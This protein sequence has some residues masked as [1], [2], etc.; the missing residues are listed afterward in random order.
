MVSSEDTQSMQMNLYNMPTPLLQDQSPP[1]VTS[2]MTPAM[3]PVVTP[4]TISSVI[5]PAPLIL[6]N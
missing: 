6:N 1:S 4:V 5:K 3:T 2:I